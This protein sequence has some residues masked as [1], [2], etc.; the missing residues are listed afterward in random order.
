MT[1]VMY[2]NLVRGVQ[3]AAYESVHHSIG[4]RRIPAAI[5]DELLEQMALAR[6]VASL[7]LSARSSAN[8][9]VRQPLSRA[10]VYAEG[11]RRPVAELIEIVAD[12][13]NVKA[14]EFVAEEGAWSTTRCCPITSCS[15][16]ASAPA[17]RRSAP[18][19]RLPTRPKSLPR[20][21]RDSLPAR[22]GR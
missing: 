15:A 7:G 5:D 10:L 13:L 1:E 3:P 6:Q 4:P 19:W 21:R 14:F 11:E 16:R 2:Q 22:P 17:S 8:I 12:E 9:K 20:P 18:P